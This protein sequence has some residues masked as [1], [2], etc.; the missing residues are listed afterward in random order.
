MFN[1]RRKNLVYR[2]KRNVYYSIFFI[3]LLMSIGYSYLN[4]TLSIGGDVVVGAN[5]AITAGNL[6]KNLQTAGNTCITKYEGNVTDQVGQTVEASNV[7]FDR[8]TDKRNILFNNMCWQVIRSTETGGLKM[9]YN[10]EPDQNNSCGISRTVHKGIVGRTYGT[11]THYTSYSM[12]SEYL[13]ATTFTYNE[14][15]DEFILVDPISAT[16]SESTYKNLLGKFTC[17]DN[18]DT[19]TTLYYISFYNDDTDAYVMSYQMNDTN[20]AGIGKSTF[21]AFYAS[22]TYSGYMFSDLFNIDDQSLETGALMG[23]DVSYSNGTYTLLP[24]SG[25]SVLGTTKDDNHHYTCNNTTG[26]CNKVRFYHTDDEYF[27]LEGVANIEEALNEMLYNDDV[28][29][30]NSSMKGVIDSWFAQNMAGKVSMLEDTVF[31]NARNVIN[32]DSNGFNK[33]GDLGDAMWFKNAT[34]NLIDLTCPNL[35]DQFAV[36]NNKAKLTYPVSL[37]Q[38]EEVNNLNNPSLLATGEPW[39][40]LSPLAFGGASMNVFFVDDDGSSQGNFVGISYDVRPVVSLA[41]N[42]RITVGTG[43]ESDPW[44]V[45]EGN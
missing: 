31:C 4:T 32:G 45:D 26:T 8:C 24:A 33:N 17:L 44:I 43:S 13:Y 9:I 38:G 36:G 10:G 19:C 15:T 40:T 42:V 3:L 20:Y 27:E 28:N 5:H 18:T 39:F 35:T 41:S 11:F 14:L 1:K 30:Y 23:N 2:K 22:P 21:N 37:I 16:W 34:E 29:R 12:N 6:L 7:Y 25:E